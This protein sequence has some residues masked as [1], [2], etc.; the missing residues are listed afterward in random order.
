MQ[1][2]SLGQSVDAAR[3]AQRLFLSCSTENKESIFRTSFSI[4]VQN[5]NE[6]GSEDT[7][8]L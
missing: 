4:E 1:N 8:D 5:P 3:G 2:D 6:I 7:V